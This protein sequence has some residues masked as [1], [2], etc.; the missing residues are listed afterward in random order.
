MLR[1]REL[2]AE[3]SALKTAE[4]SAKGIVGRRQAT[5]VR[6]CKVERR[7]PGYASAATLHTEGPNGSPEGD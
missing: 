4:E 7:S 6:H 2:G 1:K 5:L 3:R